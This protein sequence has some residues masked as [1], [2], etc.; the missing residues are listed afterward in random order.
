MNDLSL[1]DGMTED[2]DLRLI[3]LQMAVDHCTRT[4]PTD[5]KKSV[6]ELQDW[7][8]NQIGRAHV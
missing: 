3:C 5:F 7:F 2:E 8:Y 6:A 1:D 4:N